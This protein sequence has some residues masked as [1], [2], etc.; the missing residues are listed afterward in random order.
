MVEPGHYWAVM[1]EGR[2]KQSKGASISW[3]TELMA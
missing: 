1:L 2:S 3:M